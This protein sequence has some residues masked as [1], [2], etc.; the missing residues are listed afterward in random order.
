[1]IVAAGH[2]FQQG[3]FATAP[4]NTDG[5]EWQAEKARLH[6]GGRVVAEAWHDTSSPYAFFHR[7]R[8]VTAFPE[9]GEWWFDAN[10]EARLRVRPPEG[11]LDAGTLYGHIQY[12]KGPELIWTATDEAPVLIA[13]VFAPGAPVTALSVQLAVARRVVAL[14]LG[15]AGADEW[16]TVTSRVTRADLETLLPVDHMALT[17]D[18]PRRLTALVDP[19]DQSGLQRE[20]RRWALA[21]FPDWSLR[22][23]FCRQLGLTMSEVTN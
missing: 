1:M 16:L 20:P 4:Y 9:V 15:E 8:F 5:I 3:R 7:L 17:V 19:N 6:H 11:L 21:D 23:L 18:L 2:L 12:G 10:W 14:L 22:D 13:C